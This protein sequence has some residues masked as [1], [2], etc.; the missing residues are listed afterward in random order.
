MAETQSKIRNMLHSLLKD[1]KKL[2]TGQILRDQQRFCFRVTD[3]HHFLAL[4][5]FA[6]L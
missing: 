5:T 4:L 2:Q 3:W 1:D 6:G